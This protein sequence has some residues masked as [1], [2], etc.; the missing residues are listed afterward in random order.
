MALHH[1]GQLAHRLDE[2]VGGFLVLALEPH[3]HEQG[4]PQRH[5]GRVHQRHVALDHPG[6]FQQAHPPEARRG[7]QPNLFGQFL[8]L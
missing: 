2:L 8:V 3:P 7:R 5:L 1:F 6:L 4:Q